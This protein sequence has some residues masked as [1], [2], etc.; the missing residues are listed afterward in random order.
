VR[1]YC[2]S[3]M[4]EHLEF[5]QNVFHKSSSVRLHCN[6][7]MF[8]HVELKLNVIPE[9]FIGAPVLSIAYV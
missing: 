3:H 9:V 5:R 6:L 4:F 8:E 7:N 2:K 1:F